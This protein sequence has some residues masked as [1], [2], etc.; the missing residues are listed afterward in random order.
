MSQ[1]SFRE[2]GVSASVVDALAARSIHEP[3]PIQELVLP[4][5]LAGLDVLAKSP[6]GSGKTL[7]FALP[8][9][10]RTASTDSRPSALI[11]V[12][13][14]E[15]A[16]QVTAELKSLAGCNDLSV[17]SVYG[18]V[19]IGAQ[20]KAAKRAHIIVATPGRLQDLADRRLVDLSRVRILV[21]DEADRMLDMGF[22]PQVDRIVR[23][24]PRNRQTM[25]FSATLD[26][27]VGRLAHSY[28]TSPSRFET[29]PVSADRS[30]IDHR[31]VPV[32]AETK[33]ETLVDHITSTD[34]L[35]LV[36]T[37]TK[38]GAGRLVQKLA[39]RKVPAIA[40]HGDMS[41]RERERAL[42][43]FESGKVTTLVA[44]NVAARGLDVDGVTQVIN[45]DPPDEDKDYVHRTG[46]T[47][48]AGRSGTAV[49]F[50]LPD[51]Q[52]ETSR[53]ARRLGH[54][55]QFA[56]AGLQSARPKLLYTSR[57]RRRSKW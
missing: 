28:T 54:A 42:G 20:A 26:G 50:V 44:T 7:A 34:G 56:E 22:Q 29:E 6:T 41:Q 5:A 24:L 17:A 3:F 19:P 49:T 52:A 10:A 14:R 30:E 32:T 18:G 13:T 35:T 53:A 39:Q 55:D 15:L 57:N 31:F 11:L 45:F 23:Q 27:E 8:I 38:R 2:L 47:G 46:R 21:L 9:V 51:Q 48:R 25:F 16:G 43:R 12:P 4:D 36:F 1:Q 40:M 33:L 37:R